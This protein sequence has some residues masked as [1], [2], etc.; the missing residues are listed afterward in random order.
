MIMLFDLIKLFDLGGADPGA[1]FQPLLLAHLP[2][3]GA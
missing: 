3:A 2:R 1:A